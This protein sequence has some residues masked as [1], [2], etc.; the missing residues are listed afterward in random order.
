MNSFGCEI[1]SELP[2]AGAQINPSPLRGCYDKALKYA[3]GE[4]LDQFAASSARPGDVHDRLHVHAQFESIHPSAHRRQRPHWPRPDQRDPAASGS[5]SPGHVPM[6]SVI[7]AVEVPVR[8][9]SLSEGVCGVGERDRCDA[10]GLCQGV[11]SGAGGVRACRR[12]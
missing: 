2:T 5:D 1:H 6:A 10:V 3:L 8:G 12:R 7:A 11:Q 4:Y 9:R